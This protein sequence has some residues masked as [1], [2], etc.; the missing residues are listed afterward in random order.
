MVMP[1]VKRRLPVLG[2]LLEVMLS[3]PFGSVWYV[4]LSRVMLIGP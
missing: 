4:A 3:M 1:R 2:S